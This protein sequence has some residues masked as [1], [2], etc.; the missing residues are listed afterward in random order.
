[1]RPFR[2]VLA[3][4]LTTA[5]IASASAQITRSGRGYLFRI[6][7][8]QGAVTRYNTTV[9]HPAEGGVPALKV[10]LPIVQTV[11]GIHNGV[12]N[13]VVRQ[14]PMVINGNPYGPISSIQMKVNSRG[15]LVGGEIGA[16]SGITA[17]PE[18]PVRTGQTWGATVPIAAMGAMSGGASV[19]TATYRFIKITKHNGRQVAELHV[20]YSS[21]GVT[22]LQGAGV[23]YLALTD[24]IVLAS[25]MKMD[26][27]LG[28]SA[29]PTSVNVV[30]TRD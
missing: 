17:F 25:T 4:L 15:K 2:F 1:M 10:S 20:S 6:K 23:T 16:N 13:L 29:D 11:T 19:V 24:G 14:G 21:K 7:F 3:L 27:T 22:P 30:V 28:K 12:A 26:V 9:S 18:T 8:Q 5:M